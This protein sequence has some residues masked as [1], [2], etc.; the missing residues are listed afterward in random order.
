MTAS[1]GIRRL[2]WTRTV[3]A[4]LAAVQLVTAG[5]VV[6]LRS[7][8]SHTLAAVR[9]PSSAPALPPV[10]AVP[11][12]QREVIAS[13]PRAGPAVTAVTPTSPAPAPPPTLPL[14]PVARLQARLAAAMPGADGCL[15][16]KEGARVLYAGNPNTPL[17]PASTQKLLVA[18]AALSRLGPGF[19]FTTRAM[20]PAAPRD[21]AVDALWLVGSGDP[22]LSTPEYVAHLAAS[23]R[24]RDTPTTPLVV[25]ADA[26]V[27]AGV[28]SV[29]GGIHGDDGRYERLRYLPSWKPSYRTDAD[30]GALGALT[31]DGGL[32]SWQP[33]DVAAAEPAALASGALARLLATRGVAA[34]AAPDEVAP[35]AAVVLGEVRGAPLADV[36]AAMLRSSDN[37]TAELLTR[38]LDRAAGGA[39]TTAG[40]TR[41][42][43]A[44]A[45]RLGLPTGGL[46][47][48]D[49]SGLDTGDRASCELLLRALELGDRQGFGAIGAGLAVAG[50]SGTLARRFTGT[51]LAGHLAAKTGSI[52]C[53]AGMVGVVDLGRPLR[54]AL[55]TNRTCTWAAAKAVEDGVAA[56]LAAYPG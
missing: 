55:L 43:A 41:V 15:L 2:T 33:K 44:E 4:V 25:L 24:S 29:T 10:T 53:V 40:G 21:G 19:R 28:R 56:A 30:V 51:P 17:A 18:A 6:H 14:D 12:E 54:F 22:L 8:P 34:G 39:G 36:V 27:A 48:I 16:V 37:L 13:A 20:A 7:R 46:Q 42:V 38:E 23:A 5:A 26:L 50:R 47:L 49:G 3:V 32:E 9:L 11:A 1:G 31:V 52:D 35:P 45:A